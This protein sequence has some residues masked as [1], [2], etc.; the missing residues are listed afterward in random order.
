MKRPVVEA[1]LALTIDGKLAGRERSALESF[2]WRRTDALLT[3][4]KPGP[5][6]AAPR[7]VVW[8]RSDEL[9]EA[10]VV[11]A[12]NHG[13]RR[14]ICG[15]EPALLKALVEQ[16]LLSHLHVVFAPV[17]AGGARNPTLLGPAATALL[18]RS[19]P[20]KLEHFSAAGEHSRATYRV[21][22]AKK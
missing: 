19:V 11:L 2:R 14:V 8:K 22:V 7:V 12:Q 21:I 15:G 20:L 1:H 5:M 9:R 3:Q 6:P 10:L 16:E 17:V 13:V 18:P 4:K